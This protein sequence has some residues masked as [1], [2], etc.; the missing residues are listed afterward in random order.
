MGGFWEFPGGK[1]EEN[2]S[3]HQALVRE[4]REELGIEARIDEKILMTSHREESLHIDLHF[5]KARIIDGR[6]QNLEGQE[7]RWV[8]ADELETFPTPPADLE[9][10]RMLKAGPKKGPNV[11][12]GDR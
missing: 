7:F 2:E 12:I 1:L 6:P 8:D 9:L 10:I 3:L 11:G 4:L 5:F